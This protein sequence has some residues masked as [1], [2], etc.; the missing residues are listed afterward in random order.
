MKKTQ[1]TGSAF[2]AIIF[3]AILFLSGCAQEVPMP[4]V[5]YA[6]IQR[7]MVSFIV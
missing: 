4:E 6:L 3:A 5:D 2:R 7:W 1:S